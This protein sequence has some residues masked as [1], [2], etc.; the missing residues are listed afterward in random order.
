MRSKD[1][2]RSNSKEHEK[3]AS[4]QPN[5]LYNLQVPMHKNYTARISVA[6]NIEIEQYLLLGSARHVTF[7][8]RHAPTSRMNETGEG[9]STSSQTDKLY[10]ELYSSNTS[11][12]RH[13]TRST[14][15]TTYS[16]SWL[17]ETTP[18][19]PEARAKCCGTNLIESNDNS[20]DEASTWKVTQCKILQ[21]HA[22][23]AIKE[24]INIEAT[25]EAI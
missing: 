13:Q 24:T 6:F 15:Q 12:H 21:I 22:Y 3:W 23:T 5:E 25:L 20:A 14:H 18:Q 4:R 8:N 2:I 9:T 17:M 16:Y 7:R 1:L 19:Q 10:I 11:C